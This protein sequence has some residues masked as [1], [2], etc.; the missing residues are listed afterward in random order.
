MSESVDQTLLE[1]AIVA[2]GY[3]VQGVEDR[4][5]VLAENAARVVWAVVYEGVLDL[6]DDWEE[7]QAWLVELAERLS[8]EKAWELYL[9]LACGRSPES[10]ELEALEAVRRDASYARKIVVP[11]IS[12]L[13]PGTVQDYVAPLEEL[14]LET[15]PPPADAL[16]LI[17]ATAATESNNQDALAV[18]DAYRQNQAPFSGL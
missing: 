4:E 14:P 11:G 15:P 18:I 13:S 12:D 16:Q 2:A 3:R 17:Q 10:G 1:D 8:V 6:L 7:E 9:V 5:G